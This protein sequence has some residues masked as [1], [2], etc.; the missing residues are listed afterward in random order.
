LSS[1][2]ISY[3]IKNL[4]PEIKSKNEI[5]I[6]NVLFHRREKEVVGTVLITDDDEENAILEARQKMDRAISKLCYIYHKE[7]SMI[8]DGIYLV[9]LANPSVEKVRGEFV[10]MHDIGMDTFEE[11]ALSKL[12][13]LDPNKQQLAHKALGLFR[14][15]QASSDPFK[16][17][18]SY[19][20]CIHAVLKDQSNPISPESDLKKGLKLILQKRIKNFN[21]QDFY[22]YFYFVYTIWKIFQIVNLFPIYK[23]AKNKLNK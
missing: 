9:D 11:S 12:N 4:E 10:F 23:V 2:R 18:D 17:I 19:F 14:A 21:E 1:W 3:V 22:K 8:T 13:N 16:A 15:A 20:S 5:E 7:V 6:D